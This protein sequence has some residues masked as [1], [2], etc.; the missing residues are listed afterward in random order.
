MQ[1]NTMQAGTMQEHSGFRLGDRVK[2]VDKQIIVAE[3]ART[4]AM[5]GQPSPYTG[6]EIMTIEAIGPAP[7]GVGGPP[8]IMFTCRVD[9][10]DKQWAIRKFAWYLVIKA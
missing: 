6:E 9:G 5:G 10:H 8:V 1:A 2:L 3:Q 4:V 7:M